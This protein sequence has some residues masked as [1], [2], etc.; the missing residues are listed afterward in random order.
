MAKKEAHE[1]FE[2]IAVDSLRN[3]NEGKVDAVKVK[4]LEYGG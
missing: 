3:G 1:G 4:V 2:T